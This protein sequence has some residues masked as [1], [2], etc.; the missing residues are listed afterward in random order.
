[1]GAPIRVVEAAPAFM[2]GK[3]DACVKPTMP[4]PHRTG[5]KKGLPIALGYLSVSFGFGISAV[6]GGLKAIWAVLI[7]LTNLTSAGQ[8]AGL[9]ILIA[10]GPVLEMILTELVVNLRYSLMAIALTQKIERFSTGHRLLAAFG[11]TDEIFAVAAAEKGPVTP[12][13]FYGL[14]TLPYLGW[15]LGTLLGALAGDILPAS[16]TSALGLAIYAMFVAIVVPAAREDGGVGWT[17]LIACGLS[18]LFYYLSVFSFLTSGF[19]VILCAV[20][21]AALM[22]WLRPV[23]EREEAAA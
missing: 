20:V 2:T 8:L 13:Y 22:A 12:P 3:R 18:C 1:M 7:S 19:S 11:I 9:A 17:L 23:N 10:Q 6:N 5:L 21:A 14:M 16:V 15:G 4:H